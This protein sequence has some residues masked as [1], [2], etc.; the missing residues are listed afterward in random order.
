MGRDAAEERAVTSEPSWLRRPLSARW[1]IGFLC[2]YLA[3]MLLALALGAYDPLFFGAGERGG[4]GIDFFCVPKAFSNL[5]HGRSAFDTWGGEPYGPH[6]TWFVLHPAVAIWVGGY[7][8]WLPPWFAYAAWVGLTLALLA[9]CGL[10]LAHHAEST[11]RK[12]IVFGALLASPVTYLL[13]HCGN[14]H[15]IVLVSATLLLV[16]LCELGKS[17]PPALRISPRVKVASGLLLSLLSK[18]VL[19]LLVPALLVARSTRRAV[20]A[21]LAL[22]T[23]ISS[24]FI[25]VPTLNPESVGVPRLLWVAFHPQWVRQELNVYQN[26]FVLL[27]EMLDNAMHW[28]HMLAQSDYAWDHAQIF[29]LPVFA[30]SLLPVPLG[31]FRL[32][33]LAPIVLAPFLFMLSEE[34]RLVAMTWL[35][36]L[37]L[38]THFLGYAIAW[39]YQY[40]QLLVVAAALAALPELRRGRPRW[41]TIALGSLL[42]L[43]LPT[44]YALLS[45]NGLT[46][47]ERALM[48]VSRVGPALL[49]AL[50][51][52]GMVVR[53][54]RTPEVGSLRSATD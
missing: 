26:G 45:D 30:R 15:G 52:V 40:T 20:V 9:V 31:A 47:D 12:V 53:S 25:L 43:Y 38:A 14:I 44:P 21:S 4:Q 34:R 11:W 17:T 39:E 10:L 16:G 46:V 29:S 42:L 8:A 23:A 13:L 27:P 2:V 18:P 3:G 35:I 49:V 28:L 54:L 22:Y 6:A 5:L 7:L 48:R 1:G 37:T 51:A 41:V 36:I 24:A 19:I 32:T 33:A 50:A